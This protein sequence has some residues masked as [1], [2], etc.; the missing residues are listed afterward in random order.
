VPPE[1]TFGSCEQAGEVNAIGKETGLKRQ[2][3]VAAK[4]TT[5]SITKQQPIGK[6][7]RAKN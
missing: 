6:S 3:Q 2:F 5:S 4:T 1:P 7:G